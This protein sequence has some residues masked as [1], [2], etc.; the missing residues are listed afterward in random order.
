MMR[1][2][3]GGMPVPQQPSQAMQQQ[4]QTP[5]PQ[6][7]LHML[8]KAIITME[9]KGM[10]EDPR[11]A[12]LM[13]I[14]NRSKAVPSPGI[15]TPPNGGHSPGMG[16]LPPG[17][18]TPSPSMGPPP[19]PQQSNMHGMQPTPVGSVPSQPQ[20]PTSPHPSAG[21]VPPPQSQTQIPSGQNYSMPTHMAPPPSPS[22]VGYMCSSQSSS[23]SSMM[24]GPQGH[25]GQQHSQSYPNAASNYHQTSHTSASGQVHI[26]PVPGQNDVEQP[27]H[28]HAGYAQ[29]NGAVGSPHT[30]TGSGSACSPMANSSIPSSAQKPSLLT[31]AQIQQLR[32]QIMAYRLLARNQIVP[33]SIIIALQGKRNP[34]AQSVYSQRPPGA[35]S[36]VQLMRGTG[37]QNQPP[38]HGGPVMPQQ[39]PSSQSL[40]PHMGQA[41]MPPPPSQQSA[42]SPLPPQHPQMNM[43]P[44]QGGPTMSQQGPPIRQHM[45]SNAQSVPIP[46]M[47]QMQQQKQNRVTPVPKPQGIDPIEALKERENRYNY[48]IF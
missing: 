41:S 33:E 4:Q 15:T 27:H 40:H 32:A 30:E 11:Y 13:A 16:P 3:S 48:F 29:M 24:M 17:S 45:P 42:Q 6:D 18:G 19:P 39:M 7:N 8:Q 10:Q 38:G 20:P 14:A 25:S 36:P 37:P 44:S 31:H 21:G 12:Q 26:G 23:H 47:M 43:G 22:A 46:A 2:P 5:Y 35:P 1:P 28:N 34:P 9:E